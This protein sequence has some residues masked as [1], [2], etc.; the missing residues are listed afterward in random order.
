L[1]NIKVPTD[2]I[3]KGKV[4]DDI[5]VTIDQGGF[6]V[7]LERLE[8]K[9]RARFLGHSK[10]DDIRKIAIEYLEKIPQI[11]HVIENNGHFH[12][13]ES[14]SKT[15]F[16]R[17]F[18]HV[19]ARLFYPLNIKYENGERD[20]R[21]NNPRHKLILMTDL[22]KAYRVGKYAW[23]LIYED[24]IRWHSED[25][26]NLEEWC[27]K[28]GYTLIPLDA[29]EDRLLEPYSEAVMVNKKE[30]FKRGEII[31]FKTRYRGELVKG[32]FSNQIFTP[33]S[34]TFSNGLNRTS[35]WAPDTLESG[36]PNIN[37]MDM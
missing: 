10:D 9:V 7:Y 15:G 4:P 32:F 3:E 17:R 14:L 23:N 25:E 36:D 21:K 12:S 6:A 33:E 24:R 28:E 11:D 26:Q 30:V 29:T 31:L 35:S 27:K 2:L 37:S 5:Q 1:G 13:W 18:D 22:R 19:E 8:N 16:D 34:T 20:P